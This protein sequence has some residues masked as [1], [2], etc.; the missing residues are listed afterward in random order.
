MFFQIIYLEL[1]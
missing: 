1:F